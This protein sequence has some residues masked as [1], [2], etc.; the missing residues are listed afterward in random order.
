[1]GTEA[2]LKKLDIDQLRRARDLAIQMLEA[3]EAEQ[4]LVVW[5]VEDKMSRITWFS[6]AD[7]VKA[8]EY[9]LEEAREN[10]KSPQNLRPM[11]KELHL[12]P[13]LVPESEYESWGV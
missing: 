5:C 11:D 6:D 12:V 2:Y 10:A 4:K 8:A 3:K 13:V 1:M 9:L 7:Y